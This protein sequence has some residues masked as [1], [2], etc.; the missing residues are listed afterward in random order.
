M[1]KG[2]MMQ[3]KD[4]KQDVPLTEDLMREHG[5]LNRV[6]LIY[7]DIIDKIHHHANFKIDS[8]DKAVDIIQLFIEGHH[9]RME[10]DYIFPLFEKHKQQIDLIATLKEQH[11]KGRQ[12]SV[13]LKNIIAL[14]ELNNKNR[15]LIQH[16]LT[17]F[18]TMYRPHEAHEDTQIFPQVRTFMTEK[19][20]EELGELF[21]DFEHQLFGPHGFKKML[22]I[23]DGIEKELGIAD[24]NQ[25]TPKD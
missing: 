5:I 1:Q 23:L 2:Y 9:E 24:L 16:Y 7:E 15:F 13:H 12:I 22:K 6:L 21:E 14:Q 11:I 18:I 4:Y 17:E 19:E 20:F 8:L 25:F 3:K 10:E